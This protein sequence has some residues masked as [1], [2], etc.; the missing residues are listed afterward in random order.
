MKQGIKV[1]ETFVPEKDL[2]KKIDELTNKTEKLEELEENRI[3]STT[4]C[5]HK[6]ANIILNFDKGKPIGIICGQ[7]DKNEGTCLWA[8]NNKI[9]RYNSGFDQLKLKPDERYKK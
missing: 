8:S 6:E 4:C 1:P 2:E 9:C 3:I 7:Y 5:R